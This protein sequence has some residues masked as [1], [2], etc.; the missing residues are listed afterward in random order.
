MKFGHAQKALNLYLKYHWCFGMLPMP[1]HCPLDSIVLKKIPGFTQE[2][3]T[4]LDS[5]ERYVNIISAAKVQANGVPLAVWE[6][7]VYN[8]RDT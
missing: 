7:D 5:S 4:R 1:P 6:L 8:A 3:W 2:R